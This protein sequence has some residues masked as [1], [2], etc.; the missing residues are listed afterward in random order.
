MMPGH[1]GGQHRRA[2]L[3]IP[4]TCVV[5]SGLKHR[6]CDGIEIDGWRPAGRNTR[7]GASLHRPPQPRCS[8]F[9]IA[10]LL[11]GNPGVARAAPSTIV[12][13]R[14]YGLTSRVAPKAYLRMPQTADGKMPAL[15]SQTGV[16]KDTRNLGTERRPDSVRLVVSLL[17][18]RRRQ[19]APGLVP[20][21]GKIGF[22]PTGDWTFP[23][24][25][26]FVKTF[27][28]PV[29]ASNPASRRRLET[30]LLVRDSR[31]G[32]LWRRL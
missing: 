27:E 17:V 24:G 31:G 32:G 5:L 6:W 1:A 9:F 23:A 2:S 28:L 22:A 25:A 14:P 19:G 26:V 21:E 4:R 11:L 8:R 13:H 7:E 20:K 3:P 16:Y 30:R 10:A 12:P 29:D 15:L 18:R